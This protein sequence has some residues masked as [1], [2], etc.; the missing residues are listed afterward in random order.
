MMGQSS[1]QF[2]YHAGELQES[3]DHAHDAL[4]LPLYYKVFGALIVLTVLT[5]AVS[6][7]GL[8]AASIY[9]AIF[10]ALIKSGLVVGYF[11]H[12]KYDD[13]LFSVVGVVVVL[14]VI[15][16]FGLTFADIATRDAINPEWGNEAY[17]EM[18]IDQSGTGTP[19]SCSSGLNK[20]W[21]LRQE[22]FRNKAGGH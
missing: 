19:E 16:F 3:H 21:E 18:R 11:M 12:L 13:R 14:F 1:K 9:V 8:G 15:T 22:S 17:Q 4:P 2:T 7:M 5:V 10:V 6:Y 20:C